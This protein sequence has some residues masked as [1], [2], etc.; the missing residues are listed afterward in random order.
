M[1]VGLTI[2]KD[3][4][5]K[6]A[7]DIARSFQRSFEDVGTLKGF[8][9]ATPEADLIALGYTSAEVASLKTAWNDLAQ[10]TTIWAGQ[11]ALAAPKDFREFVRRLWGVGAF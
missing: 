6:R 8:L 7:G 2:T 9:D 5:D 3:E 4:I 10:L 1:A 11:A